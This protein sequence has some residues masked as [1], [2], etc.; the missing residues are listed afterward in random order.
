M[1]ESVQQ[2]TLP[3]DEIMVGIGHTPH[4]LKRARKHLPCVV[5]VEKTETRGLR[6]ARNS[7][8]IAAKSQIIAFLDDD[9]IATPDWLRFLAEGYTDPRVLGSGGE[10][11]PLWIAHKPAWLAGE[12][13]WVVGCSYRGMPQTGT[14]IRNPVGAT[15]SFRR[16][17]FEA[18]GGFRSEIGRVGTR[19]LGC[20]ETELCI[21]ARQRG[22][23]RRF[24]YQVQASV[25]S[26]RTSWSYFF[27]RCYSEGVS[28]AF[29]SRY[30][31]AKDG[32]A[33]ERTYTLQTLPQGILRG[34]ADAL[35]HHDLNGLVRVGAILV[36]SVA[37]TGGTWEGVPCYKGQNEETPL[38]GQA[39]FDV[40]PGMTRCPS[41]ILVY[42][43]SLVNTTGR[44][45]FYEEAYNAC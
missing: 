42:K 36:G 34:F 12:F 33:S 19:P 20:E 35:F 38:L 15:R 32:L 3:S 2:Q 18:A 28:N 8:L 29:V 37:T 43:G 14:T 11:T 21:R 23:Q 41:P 40:T 25:A 13:F 6:G 10:V 5:V 44:N 16:E 45:S 24:L 39:I 27:S 31:G 4:V 26:N 1:V 30:V 22:P 9:A 17:V 7:G